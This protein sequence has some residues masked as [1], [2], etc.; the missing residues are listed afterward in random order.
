MKAYIVLALSAFALATASVSAEAQLALSANDGK[1]PLLGD[2][3]TSH[4][5]DNLAVIDLNHLPPK[6]I[7]TVDVPSSMIGPPTAAAVAHDGSFALVSNAQKFD[8]SDATKFVL[9]DTV[10]VID[11]KDPRH[12]TVIQTLHVGD[13]ATGISF[14][15]NDTLA[16]VAATGGTVSVF[17]VAGKKVTFAEKMQLDPKAHP[18][19]V[20]ISPDGKTALVTQR[21]ANGVVRLAIDGDKV[22]ETGME[23]PTGRQTYGVVFSPD[24][25]FAYNTNLGGRL[26]PVNE[27][28]PAQAV[29]GRAGGP[30][31][32][33]RI[34]TVTVI[35]VNSNKVVNTV[36]VGVTPEHLTLS[37][38]G[39]YLAVT[40]GNGSSSRPE[41]PYFHPD[42]LLKIYSVDGAKLAEV[43]EAKTGAWGQGAS[44]NKNHTIILLQSGAAK[45]IEVYRFDGKSLIRQPAT[46]KFDSR[47]G[48]ISTALS[49]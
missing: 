1:Q 42:G 4:T 13:G 12:P 27:E 43:A 6:V 46:I 11:L 14:N 19:D 20:A 40:I 25:R 28:P 41:S 31:R 2:I 26:P 21:S 8:P 10:S 15:R 44:W 35:D 23:I 33:P 32:A 22:T 18:V 5:A 47:P 17:S 16:L 38:D 7:G 3:P 49:R 37:H 30:P 29:G 45:D 39:K 48:S 36:D 9:D 34:G 24:G